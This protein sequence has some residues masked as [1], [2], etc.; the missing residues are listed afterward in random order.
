ERDLAPI[1]RL[2]AELIETVQAFDLQEAI[3]NCHRLFHESNSHF[4]IVR[5]DD[6]VVG[7]IN[8]TTR[9]SILHPGASGLIDELV[10]AKAYR[11][12]GIGRKL[13][14]AAIDKCR[15]LGCCEVEVS[16]EKT[17]HRARKFYRSC[18]FE[19]DAVLLETEC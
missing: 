6:S 11:R 15:E 9:Q 8:F 10:V 17:N 7:F 19:E 5:M 4:L 3:R 1:G 18:G 2:L 13:I 12:R 16:T 14:S